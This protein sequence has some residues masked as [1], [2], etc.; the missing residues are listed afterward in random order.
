M[1]NELYQQLS[2]H[3]ELRIVCMVGHEIAF[4]CVVNETLREDQ[5]KRYGCFIQDETR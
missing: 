4:M 5:S 1:K 2:P 3:S